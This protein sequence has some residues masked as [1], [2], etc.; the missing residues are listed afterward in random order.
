MPVVEEERD[1]QAQ[2]GA[3]RPEEGCPQVGFGDSL[4]TPLDQ[5]H[6]GHLPP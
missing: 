5:V 6:E 1:S 3:A 2:Q 4:F